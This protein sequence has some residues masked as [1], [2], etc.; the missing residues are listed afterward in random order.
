MH[1]SV[2]HVVLHEFEQLLR[3]LPPVQVISIHGGVLHDADC[4]DGPSQGVPLHFG[5]GWSHLRVRVCSPPL[6]LA[7]QVLHSDHGDQLPSTRRMTT[8]SFCLLSY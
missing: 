4:D 8:F 7:V 6:Q 3:T 1:V 2:E 5:A